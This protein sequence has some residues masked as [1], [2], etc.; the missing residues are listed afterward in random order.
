M[1]VTYRVRSNKVSSSK[2]KSAIGV[3]RVYRGFEHLYL[4]LNRGNAFRLHA[5]DKNRYLIKIFRA[6][7]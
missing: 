7:K 4:S 2:F 1:L 3:W 5:K 6:V